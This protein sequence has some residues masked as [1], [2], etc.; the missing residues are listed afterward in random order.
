MTSYASIEVN[1]LVIHGD[2]FNADHAVPK[3]YVDTAVGT[4]TTRIDTMLAGSVEAYDTLVELKEL[5][6]DSSSDLAT[7]IS[8]KVGEL[9]GAISA[10]ADAARGF[11]SGLRMD[12]GG[13]IQDRVDGIQ[14][15]NE[16]LEQETLERQT[17]VQEVRDAVSG[18][19]FRAEEAEQGLQNQH[20]QF[21]ESNSQRINEVQGQLSGSLVSLGN[22]TEEKLGLKLDRG[23]F[24][25]RED[26]ALQIDNDY[27][28]YLGTNWRLRASQGAKRQ[29]LEFEHSSDEVNWSL[30]IPFIRGD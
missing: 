21:T 25:T 4:A 28:L 30:A 12:I 7:A 27:H 2:Q 23:G 8:T 3:S 6:D 17:H 10:E 9:S 1:Q 14:R 24:A 5:M 15:V 26:G 22:Y 13:E 16:A 11:E 20:D 18:E 29:R 19:I